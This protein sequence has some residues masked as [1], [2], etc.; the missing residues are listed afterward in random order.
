VTGDT[1]A[2]ETSTSV[3]DFE[4]GYKY[5]INQHDDSTPEI[6]LDS[7]ATWRRLIRDDHN[8]HKESEGEEPI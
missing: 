7:L 3:F 2:K 5:R 4:E 1:T 8:Q 6:Y